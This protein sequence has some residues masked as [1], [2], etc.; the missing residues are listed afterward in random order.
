[1]T[2]EWDKF[3]TVRML[4]YTNPSPP[5]H[6]VA[7]DHYA[8][9]LH[10]LDHVVRRGY[11]R[12]AL[13]TSHAFEDRMLQSYSSAYL[14]ATRRQDWPTV[15]WCDEPNERVFA[16]WYRKQKPDVLLVSYA[17]E[18]YA[19]VFKWVEALRLR[20]PQDIGVV[21]LCMPDKNYFHPAGFPDVSGIDEQLPQLAAR[22]V[23][24]L[25]HLLENF[26]TGVPALPMR[27]LMQGKWHEGTTVRPFLAV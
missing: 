16:A 10:V 19:Q 13:V 17:V 18:F 11:T 2:L 1:M 9:L 22:S 23:D 3:S 27:H 14:G 21:M 7:S 15:F 25:V 8:S 5:L 20:I 6:V 4:D 24:F 12:P 26:E